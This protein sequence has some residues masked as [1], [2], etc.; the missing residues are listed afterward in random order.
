MLKLIKIFILTI[1][2]KS[3]LFAGPPDIIKLY[4]MGEIIFD[5]TFQTKEGKTLVFESSAGDIRVYTS[6]KPEVRIKI[7][8]D[9]DA[10]DRI[11][12]IYSENIDGIKIKVKKI[13]SFWGF[14]SKSF[15]VDYDLIVPKK[16]NLNIVSG[17][18]DVYLKNLLGNVRIKTS[19]GDTKIEGVEGEVYVSASGGDIFLNKIIGN[20]KS[21]TSGGDIILREISGEINSSTTGGDIKIQS[22]NGSI[23]AKTTGGDIT[24]DYAGENKGIIA[25]TVGGDIYLILDKTI[26]GFFSLSTIGGD[27]IN[28]FNLTSLYEKKSSKLEG[29]L[30]KK[31]PRIQCKTTGGDIKIIKRK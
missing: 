12:L 16:Y 20:V 28:E 26:E 18:G 13:S 3:F 9:E 1:T 25:S 2:F 22:K 17:S 30:N 29:E 7:Y 24:I 14:F 15:Y 5:K 10:L 6:D 21:H 11:D 8:G 23:N 19:G 27:I 4:L 31:E